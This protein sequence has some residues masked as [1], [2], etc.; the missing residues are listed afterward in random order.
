MTLT[1]ELEGPFL[2]RARVVLREDHRK[3][4]LGDWE[5]L[6]SSGIPHK[7]RP[8]LHV[9]STPL[10]LQVE[11]ATKPQPESKPPQSQD[12][13]KS[14]AEK[15]HEIFLPGEQENWKLNN[16]PKDIDR[17][18]SCP[19][20]ADDAYIDWIAEYAVPPTQGRANSAPHALMTPPLPPLPVED[21]ASLPMFIDPFFPGEPIFV[22]GCDESAHP[23]N[24]SDQEEYELQWKDNFFAE[25]EKRTREREK[26]ENVGPL[27]VVNEKGDI[28]AV[29]LKRKRRFACEHVLPRPRKVFIV[30]EEE[31]DMTLQYEERRYIG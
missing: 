13:Y 4:Y 17:R 26:R 24:A 16:I 25:A 30:G 28:V 23:E 15:F 6:A 8:D 27:D 2:I 3:V 18:R 31:K 10:P 11:V 9:P 7:T 22:T 19:L 29:P 14:D 20:F 1:R 5:A 12:N 21:A